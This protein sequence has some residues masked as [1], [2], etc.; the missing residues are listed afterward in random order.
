MARFLT[1]VVKSM[2]KKVCLKKFLKTKKV[3]CNPEL[4]RQNIPESGGTAAE[5]SVAYNFQVGVRSMANG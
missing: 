5:G 1:G 3:G 4:F 2:F